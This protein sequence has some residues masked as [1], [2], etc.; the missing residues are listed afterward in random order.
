MNW[1]KIITADKLSELFNQFGINN[2]IESF[3]RTQQPSVISFMIS[4][5]KKNPNI[6]LQQ[7]QGIVQNQQLLE[8]HELDSIIPLNTQL[9]TNENQISHN[10]QTVELDKSPYRRVAELVDAAEATLP[11]EAQ[12][13]ITYFVGHPP[14]ALENYDGFGIGIMQAGRLEDAFGDKPTAEGIVI[15]DQIEAA[16]N[17]IRKKLRYDVG[18]TIRLY[19]VQRPVTEEKKRNV[20]SWTSSKQFAEYYAEASPVKLLTDADIENAVKT[21]RK[22][23]E[24]KVRGIIYKIDDY[25]Y[26]ALYEKDGSF[27]TGV[28]SDEESDEVTLR[29]WLK[30]NQTEL[31][32]Q[33]DE[34]M[35]NRER[36]VEAD[37]P[38][39]DIVWVT[40]RAGQEEFIVKNKQETRPYSS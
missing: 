28:G 38:V 7:L 4:E 6:S 9:D 14:D 37:V 30:I 34:A 31:Q 22:K 15:K 26:L 40:N 27:I 36:I 8:N 25:G 18:E 32:E 33:V 2:D 39:D 16:M 19:R 20:L 29:H 23:G 10:K 13:A 11:Y 21:Y 35:K 24:V 1:Y 3:I 17:Q 12:T 5:I